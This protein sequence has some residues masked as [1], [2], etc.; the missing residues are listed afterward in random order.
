MQIRVCAGRWGNVC[1]EGSG[2]LQGYA[3][4]GAEGLIP[5]PGWA[6]LGAPLH[7]SGRAPRDPSPVLRPAP[8]VGKCSQVASVRGW[9][10]GYQGTPGGI[11][12]P[13]CSCSLQA[14]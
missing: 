11:L 14:V 7:R 4:V 2:E 8:W 13:V 12:Y 9:V 10:L 3:R 6:G 1:D 5:P